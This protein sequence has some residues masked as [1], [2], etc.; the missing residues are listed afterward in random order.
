MAQTGAPP[1][2]QYGPFSTNCTGSGCAHGIYSDPSWGG[3]YLGPV[4]SPVTIY[5]Y[6][7][8]TSYKGNNEYDELI[9]GGGWITDYY[10]NFSGQDTASQFGIP[11]C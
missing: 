1:R 10:V 6:T 2:T 8:G 9:N 11:H 5:C 4:T 3:S 7:T